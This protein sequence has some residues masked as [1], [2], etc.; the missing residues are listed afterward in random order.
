MA[1]RYKITYKGAYKKRYRRKRR[2]RR[3]LAPKR[4][5]GENIGALIGKG[6]Q[7]YF[8]AMTGFGDYKVHQN[9][10]MPSAST[11]DPPVMHNAKDN[12]TIIRHR[13]YL[14]DI[15]DSNATF[16][17]QSFPINPGLNST[18][19][20]LSSIAGQFEQYEMRGLVFE[21]KSLSSD[22]VLNSAGSPG[23]GYVCM[24]TEYNSHNPD[25]L[26]KR[27]MENHEFAV[28]NKPSISFLHPVE[29]KKSLTTIPTQYVRQG[30]LTNNEDILLYDLGKFQIAVGG[31]QGS[32]EGVAGELW[33]TYEIA[34]LKPILTSTNALQALT[35]HF[36]WPVVGTSTATNPFLDAVIQPGSTIN[37]EFPS[38]GNRIVFPES[39]SE[40]IFMIFLR[41]NTTSSTSGSPIYTIAYA[42]CEA[43]NMTKNASTNFEVLPDFTST[44]STLNNGVLVFIKVT[45]TSPWVTFTLTSGAYGASFVSRDLYITQLNGYIT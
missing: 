37:C 6:A 40:G 5:I 41:T 18:F 30:A 7:H 15:Q 13:E 11:M 19:P 44:T 34:L 35:D 31:M 12:V 42:D 22:A 38:P 20:W 2:V 26:S 16:T 17:R 32:G 1:K 43:Y 36:S 25:F 23:L 9:S 45:G 14:G 3:R 33:V 39:V 10:L 8:K 27:D 24:A 4:G 29:C 21:F 28:S